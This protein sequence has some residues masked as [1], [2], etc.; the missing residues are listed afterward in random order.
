MTDKLPPNLLALFAPRPALRYLPP[1]D[2]APESRQT[3]RVT[4]VAAYLPALKEKAANAQASDEGDIDP[5]DEAYERPPTESWMEKRDRRI[6]EKQERQKWLTSEGAK[7]LFKP[8]D[9]PNIRGDPF[10]T[11]FVSRLSYDTDVR[12]LEREFGR[13]GPIER[14]RIVTDNGESTKE[15]KKSRKGKSRGYAFIVYE[16]ERDMKSMRLPFHFSTTIHCRT[17]SLTLTSQPPTKNPETSSSE[18]VQSSATSSAVSRSRP[19]G[20]AVSAAEKAAA[21]TAK[22]LSPDQVGTASV[23]GRRR[24]Q[25]V[26]EAVGSGEASTTVEVV[27]EEVAQAVALAGTEMVGSEAEGMVVA[28][29]VLGTVGVTA[30][31]MVRL[32]GQEEV[33]S[34]VAVG[35]EVEE[36]VEAAMVV[37]GMKIERHGM[38]TMSLCQLEEAALASGTGMETEVEVG[39]VVV[40]DRRGLTKVV[41][42]TIRARGPDGTDQQVTV[43]VTIW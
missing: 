37:V 29:V 34:A 9:D 25:E 31:L 10:K 43:T 42:M 23:E 4:G 38:L 36:E 19:G 8:A 13:F 40:E 18:A 14:V 3:A 1:S 24:D 12:D 20:H 35:M 7:E 16:T 17:D 21:D 39:M 5:T 26:S 30:H 41:G 33:G 2:F 28:E 6:I 32:R 22:L 27:S 11:L 15:G